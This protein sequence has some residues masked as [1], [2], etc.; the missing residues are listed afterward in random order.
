MK[1]IIKAILILLGILGTMLLEQGCRPI[2]KRM[3]YGKY[4]VL[5]YSN[6]PKG[7]Y[8]ITIYFTERNNLNN[9]V[10]TLITEL[11]NDTLL[12]PN[13]IPP[14]I[15]T[16]KNFRMAI[17]L[18][19]AVHLYKHLERTPGI[20]RNYDSWEIPHNFIIEIQNT[21][22]NDTLSEITF[23]NDPKD[24][25]LPDD[26]I[27]ATL[28]HNGTSINISLQNDFTIEIQ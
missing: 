19:N 6:L 22:Y 15:D 14:D 16:I 24:R 17:E 21:N 13:E 10:D 28:K 23:Y 26:A 12:I 20:A 8:N 4:L 1:R 3:P 25:C 5:N 11:S 7:S 18:D 9:I 27:E 2:C